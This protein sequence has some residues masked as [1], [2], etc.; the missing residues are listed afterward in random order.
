MSLWRGNL[1]I[2]PDGNLILIEAGIMATSSRQ[3]LVL[4]KGFAQ[5]PASLCA[6]NYI[7]GA[8]KRHRSLRV[9]KKLKFFN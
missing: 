2:S 8:A 6:A 4:G 9:A 5:T 1:Q 7:I 3:L